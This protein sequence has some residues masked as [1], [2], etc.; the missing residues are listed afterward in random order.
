V[1]NMRRNALPFIT[2]ACLI[3]V[4]LSSANKAVL[5]TCEGCKL[6]RLEQVKIFAYQDLPMYE[7]AAFK[8]VP[9]K[10][11]TMVFY[12]KEMKAVERVDLT[13][14]DDRAALNRMMEER[15]FRMKSQNQGQ[16]GEPAG[17][18]GQQGQMA[19]PEDGRRATRRLFGEL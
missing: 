6:V 19:P 13:R 11:P 1:D 14:M 2:V 3:S 16:P 7:N 4:A 5:E 12:D 17:P 8:R 10:P 9:G 18:W 15:G